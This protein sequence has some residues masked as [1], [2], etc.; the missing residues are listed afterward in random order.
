MT[1]KPS[2]AHTQTVIAAGRTYLCQFR[3]QRHGGYFV[4]CP[5]FLP[6]A[7]Y[8]ETLAA[9]RENARQAIEDWI[10]YADCSELV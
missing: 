9:A 6:L 1:T 5:Q 2:G 7:A 8:G 4:S 3:P 10:A